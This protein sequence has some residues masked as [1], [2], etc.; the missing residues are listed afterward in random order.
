M[1]RTLDLSYASEYDLICDKDRN[2]NTLITCTFMDNSVETLFDFTPYSGATL[3]V[4]NNSGTII[5]TFTTDDN[6]IALLADGV[7]QLLKSAD[8]MNL[9]RAGVYNYDM[10]LSN[11]DKP[12]RAFL[13]GLITYNQNI[14][15]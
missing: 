12:K 8:D 5:M 2:L 11:S 14:A 7:F 1:A 4:K 9:V 3:V 6:S 15:N 10:Y 13:R